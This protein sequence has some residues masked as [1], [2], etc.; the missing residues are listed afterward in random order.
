MSEPV[1]RTTHLHRSYH[2]IQAVQDLNLMV[3]P[4]TIF[5]LL[6][7]NGAGKTTTI[8]MLLGLLSP[9]PG[10]GEGARARP[11]RRTLFLSNGASAMSRKI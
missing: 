5:G 6:G 4:G 11:P 3:K 1:I 7:N 2:R 8:R 10:F 9:T